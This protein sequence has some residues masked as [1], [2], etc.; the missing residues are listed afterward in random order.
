M[1]VQ[2]S[3]KSQWCHLGGYTNC[4]LPMDVAGHSFDWGDNFVNGHLKCTFSEFANSLQTV[5]QSSDR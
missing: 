4:L 1:C 2:T 5:S 3:D